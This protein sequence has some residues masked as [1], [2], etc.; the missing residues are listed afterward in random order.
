MSFTC[1]GMKGK[2]VCILWQQPWSLKCMPA[3]PM[4][5]SNLINVLDNATKFPAYKPLSQTQL[6]CKCTTPQI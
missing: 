6:P 4:T 3:T 1:D 2:L 5:M